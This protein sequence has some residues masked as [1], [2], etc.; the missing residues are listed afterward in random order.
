MSS[1]EVL[2]APQ[3][4]LGLLRLPFRKAF[5]PVLTSHTHQSRHYLVDEPQRG[6][7]TC[8]GCTATEGRSCTRG[9][10]LDSQF[11]GRRRRGGSRE[12]SGFATVHPGI[13]SLCMARSETLHRPEPQCSGLA[14]GNM[15]RP[16]FSLPPPGLV[17]R[18]PAQ[19][20]TVLHNCHRGISEPQSS[21][22]R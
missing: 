4:G 8:K 10:S 11:R 17:L 9:Q 20:I 3:P 21:L 12:G 19:G 1:G 6:F 22:P 16:R 14:R 5:P 18:S 7:A 13:Q 2:R 15:A